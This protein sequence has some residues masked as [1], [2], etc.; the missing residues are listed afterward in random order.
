MA[1]RREKGEK[2]FWARRKGREGEIQEFAPI[3]PVN[4]SRDQGGV[5]DL[6]RQPSKYNPGRRA[7]F[8]M[9][10][11][12]RGHLRV[13]SN[14]LAMLSKKVFCGAS[15]P[16]ITGIAAGAPPSAPR[17]PSRVRFPAA[18]VQVQPRRRAQDGAGGT[19]CVPTEL[20]RGERR[21]ETAAWE[22][23]ASLPPSRLS[24]PSL[25]IPAVQLAGWRGRQ[26]WGGIQRDPAQISA[27]VLPRA[28]SHERHLKR[29]VQ[30]TECKQRRN[31]LGR[32]ALTRN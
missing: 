15:K 32:M 10:G 22:L 11:S 6:F 2:A 24:F 20:A 27:P 8:P 12:F 9:K 18:R 17:C 23:T 16:F 5:A 25:L 28:G 1:R 13:P 7:L 26:G 19:R 3:P 21:G 4:S 14:L 31:T 29:F 30:C